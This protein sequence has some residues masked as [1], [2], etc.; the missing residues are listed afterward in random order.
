MEVENSDDDDDI[1]I[2]QRSSYGKSKKDHI[3]VMNR[4]VRFS[5]Q[6]DNEVMFPVHHGPTE[7]EVTNIYNYGQDASSTYT[8]NMD[9]CVATLMI[10]A[11]GHGIGG[12]YYSALAVAVVT[13]WFY[14]H[15]YILYDTTMDPDLDNGEDIRQYMTSLFINIDEI[16]RNCPMIGFTPQLP[17]AQIFKHGGT[18]L[19]VAIT[20]TS[21]T[22]DTMVIAASAGDSP[23]RVLHMNPNQEDEFKLI[24]ESEEDNC[25]SIRTYA[26]Y[27]RDRINSGNDVK[28]CIYFRQNNT[29]HPHLPL[30]KI[31]IVTEPEPDTDERQ[32]RALDDGRYIQVDVDWKNVRSLKKYV[33]GVTN[34]GRNSSVP[35]KTDYIDLTPSAK[36]LDQQLK[37]AQSI[38]SGRA[39]QNWGASLD[40][41]GQNLRGFDP[42]AE[43][44]SSIPRV[45]YG[46]FDADDIVAVWVFS[47]GINDALYP[48]ELASLSEM[49]LEGKDGFLSHEEAKKILLGEERDAKGKMVSNKYQHFRGLNWHQGW[50]DLSVQGLVWGAKNSFL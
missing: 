39:W 9:D 15:N 1:K 47:D 25:D 5:V 12:E 3:A 27:A 4:M 33:S 42:D 17:L 41:V 26:D 35:L 30:Y 50:D 7:I 19:S 44:S 11:D 6:V 13:R 21:Q 43:G 2:I 16:I 46:Q 49:L 8:I 48:H 14:V 20:Y 24:Y 23:I 32:T 36:T 34:N 31:T 37:G 40:G 28:P 22:H 10:V 18:T 45:F 38:N 29:L